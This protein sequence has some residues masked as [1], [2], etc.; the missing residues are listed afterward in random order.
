[1]SPQPPRVFTPPDPS[2]LEFDPR[3][4]DARDAMSA[5]NDL[6]AA[7]YFA[8]KMTQPTISR[9]VLNGAEN[10]YEVTDDNNASFN[11]QSVSVLN[12]ASFPIYL[13]SSQGAVQSGVP[14]PPDK[15][16]RMPLVGQNGA[17]VVAAD[18]S[19]LG[20]DELTIILFR[21]PLP[22]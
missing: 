13:G 5:A 1:M 17:Y 11:V 6:S 16:T 21:W 3:S 18:P 15:L 10:L 2:T 8:S 14:F 4:K 9:V 7:T 22:D 20:A 12:G 19:D